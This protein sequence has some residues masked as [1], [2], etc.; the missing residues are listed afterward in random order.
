MEISVEFI[1]EIATHM[2]SNLLQIGE[3]DA[4]Q[5]VKRFPMNEFGTIEIDN[6]LYPGFE[7]RIRRNVTEDGTYNLLFEI[8]KEDKVWLQPITI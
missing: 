2:Y 5:L 1:Q 6:N 8:K 4:N 7:G 3:N